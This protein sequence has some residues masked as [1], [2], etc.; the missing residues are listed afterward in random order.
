M[1]PLEWPRRVDAV[2]ETLLQTI[3]AFTPPST[4]TLPMYVSLGSVQLRCEAVAARLRPGSRA[5]YF[6]ASA[7][8]S[9]RLQFATRF[10]ERRCRQPA[11]R[12]GFGT[13][14]RPHSLA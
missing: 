14:D 4:G 7:V 10:C 6:V 3:R 9:R 8:A 11:R 13:R 1:S 5:A 12:F 2:I